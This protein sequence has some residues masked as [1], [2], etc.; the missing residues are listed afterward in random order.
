MKPGLFIA[1]TFAW[2]WAIAIAFLL[3]GLPAGRG[4]APVA[5]FAFALGPALVAWATG[6]LPPLGRVF[7]LTTWAA[8]L[9]PV[10][11]TWGL[12]AG[13]DALGV[14][15]L[16]L[17]GRAVVEQALLTNGD[18][19]AARTSAFGSG[20]VPAAAA[21]LRAMLLGLCVFGPVALAEES[22]WRG[23]IFG[24]L[25]RSSPFFGRWAGAGLWVIWSL[26]LLALAD[27]LH[28][29]PA[30]LA[31]GVV[32]TGLRERTGGVLASALV[33][34]SFFGVTEF[35][36]FVLGPSNPRFADPL[37]PL[38]FGGLLF[39]AVLAGRWNHARRFDLAASPTLA[40]E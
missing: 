5:T 31:L 1:L 30:Y 19:E 28:Q 16:D 15:Q 8:W 37:G 9:F 18:V 34:G 2:S 29:A 20:R 3:L 10:F 23:V 40:E 13:L 11:F 7:R 36:A 35:G 27:S 39:L 25:R 12:L 38:G 32:L 26:P 17:S 24:W 22:V 6:L 21:T 14:L 4:V 33:R